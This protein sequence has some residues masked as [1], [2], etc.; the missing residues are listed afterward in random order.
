M[1]TA[2]LIDS[3][4][5]AESWGSAGFFELHIKRY[6]AQYRHIYIS[7]CIKYITTGRTH[8]WSWFP[9]VDSLL[10]FPLEKLRKAWNPVQRLEKVHFLMLKNPQFRWKRTFM[11][12]GLG[13]IRRIMKWDTCGSAWGFDTPISTWGVCLI[14]DNCWRLFRICFVS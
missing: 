6:H 14:G 3:Y 2:T 4:E 8:P 7:E 5:Y 11:S 1:P 13:C 10:E 9:Y 12:M